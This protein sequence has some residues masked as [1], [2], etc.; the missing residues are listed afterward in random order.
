MSRDWLDT[1]RRTALKL[2]GASAAAAGMSGSAAASGPTAD[3]TYTPSA[4]KN[5]PVAFD[6][7]PSSDD[8]VKYQWVLTAPDG[9]QDASFER[10][11]TYSFDQTG[12]WDVDLTV[13]DSND[14]SDTK[15][16]EVTVGTGSE[17]VAA[18]SYAPTF[19]SVGD[20]VSFDGSAAYDPD[21]DLD[22]YQWV[23]YA[24]DGSQKAEFVESP[25]ITV[26]QAGTWEVYYNPGDSADNLGQ[27]KKYIEV[28]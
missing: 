1:S 26:D 10:T 19:P 16:G 13:W 24:P 28:K 27:M 23:I 22:S 6:A 15:Y 3:Y 25:T 17:P 4:I 2:L 18:F 7:A 12:T 5:R 20:E 8:V 11:F 21:D 9:S 14:N